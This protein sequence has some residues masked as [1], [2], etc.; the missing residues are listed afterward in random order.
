M[1]FIKRSLEHFKREIKRTELRSYQQKT[2]NHS[3]LPVL[4]RDI[5]F[6]LKFLS[7][8]QY[9]QTRTMKRVQFKEDCVFHVKKTKCLSK[10]VG[11]IIHNKAQIFSEANPLHDSV[12]HTNKLLLHSE[13]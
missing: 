12:Y 9:V 13:F 8:I 7:L 5:H 3:S 2:N 10:Y 11:N 1:H 6:R 4:D